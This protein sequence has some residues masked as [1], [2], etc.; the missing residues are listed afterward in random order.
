MTAGQLTVESGVVTDGRRAVRE[1]QKQRR[2]DDIL[3]A[4]W[5]LFGERP[6]A[7]ITVGEVAREV[8]L[9]K[10][11]IYLYFGTKEELF[12]AA[13]ERQLVDWFEHIDVRLEG[14][15]GDCGVP[16]VVALLCGSLGERP[17]LAHALAIMHGIFEQNAGFEA[18]LRFKRTLLSRLARTGALLEECLPLLGTG[19]GL[20]SLLRAHAFIVGLWQI[21]DPPPASLRAV[22][23]PGMEGFRVDFAEEFSETMRAL[24]RG[25][26]DRPGE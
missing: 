19:D 14:M 25:M 6:Y 3:G 24:L 23:E 8:G 1:D 5:R 21:A 9:A 10:G 11:T 13:L 17:A 18:T 20:R 22:A 12:L 7:G 2:R 4:A 16:E 26:Q 15:R